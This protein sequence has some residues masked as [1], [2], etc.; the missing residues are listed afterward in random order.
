MLEGYLL[1]KLGSNGSVSVES[2]ASLDQ[3]VRTIKLATEAAGFRLETL[4]N[5]SVHFDVIRQAKIDIGEIRYNTA[6]HVPEYY[7]ENTVAFSIDS[8]VMD[9]A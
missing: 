8:P 4:D 6:N 5:Q 1:R 2:T 7:Y 3:A 9:W